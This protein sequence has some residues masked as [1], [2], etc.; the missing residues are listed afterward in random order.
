M[1]HQNSWPPQSFPSGLG[2]TLQQAQT[3]GR[4]EANVQD[5]E[6][7]LTKL[8]N[9]ALMGMSPI[10][11]VQIGIGIAVLGGALVGKWNWGEALPIIGRAFVGG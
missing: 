8:E 2:I 10:Q 1:S 11:F 9:K 3:L 5:H 6:R 7:R 4:L